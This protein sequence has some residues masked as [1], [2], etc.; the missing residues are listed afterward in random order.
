MNNKTITNKRPRTKKTIADHRTSCLSLTLMAIAGK[1]T[2][3]DRREQ[4][5]FKRNIS[6]DGKL[7][8]SDKLEKGNDA[9]RS[10]DIHQA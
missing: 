6:V 5:V 2:I 9:V 8:P 7:M 4:H 10:Q 1:K 3:A